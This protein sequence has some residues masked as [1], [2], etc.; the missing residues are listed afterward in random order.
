MKEEDGDENENEVEEYHDTSLV[1]NIQNEGEDEYINITD[2]DE[3]GEIRIIIHISPTN[4]II[5]DLL[6]SYS[7]STTEASQDVDTSKFVM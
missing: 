5:L 1:T 4:I 7:S 2:D 3:E 6:A